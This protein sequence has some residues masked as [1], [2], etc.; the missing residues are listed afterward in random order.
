MLLT[1]CEM[2]RERDWKSAKMAAA[3]S[4]LERAEALFP[5]LRDMVRV[6]EV[7]SPATFERYTANT[8]GAFY[9]FE[10]TRSMYGEAKMP[11]ATHLTNLYQ[12]GHWGKPG[13]SVWNVMA[14]GYTTARTILA[15]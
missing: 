10:N 14:N 9:G 13:G 1:F 5:G 7:G 8:A 3:E 4:M 2:G 6:M 11:I 15:R 12:T